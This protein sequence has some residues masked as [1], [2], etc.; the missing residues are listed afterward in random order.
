MPP[1]IPKKKRGRPSKTAPAAPAPSSSRASVATSKP[2][3]KKKRKNAQADSDPEITDGGNSDATTSNRKKRN[4]DSMDDEDDERSSARPQKRPK[5]QYLRAH[6]RHI[7][8]DTI[9]TKWINLPLPAQ[10]AVRT[11]FK[12][13]KR[14]VLA[15]IREGQRR[16]EAELTLNAVIQKLERQLPRM[17]FPPKTKEAHLDLEKVLERNRVLEG[18]LTPALHWVELLKVEIEKEEEA[19]DRDRV[20]LAE[21]EANAKAEERRRR[22]QVKKAHPLLTESL[23]HGYEGDDAES[24]GL[25][26][27]S[28]LADALLLD[29]PDS[30]LK[31]LLEQLQS[32]LESMQANLGHLEGI[33]G[34]I[35]SAREALDDM[36]FKQAT[37]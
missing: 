10:Q 15:S 26:P 2:R 23:D 5:Y 18:E 21:L 20:A 14:P 25:V 27:S 19:L 13:T 31:P 30:D 8:Q 4:A 11:L 1:S 29:S 9:T 24:I 32:H 3:P 37:A 36:L 6:T 17:P 12:A 28:M 35:L 16:T 33:D 22:K 7:P 34:A